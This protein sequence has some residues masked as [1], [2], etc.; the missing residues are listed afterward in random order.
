MSKKKFG[1]KNQNRPPKPP[2]PAK[3]QRQSLPELQPAPTRRSGGTLTAR[4]ITH[5]DSIL[6]VPLKFPP[7]LI[8][9][10]TD[11]STFE[12]NWQHLT[13]AFGLPDPAQF[14]ALTVPVDA[15]D[16]RSLLR[17]VQVCE[18]ISTYSVVSHK[19]GATLSMKNG[20]HEMTFE[21]VDDEEAVGFSVRFRQLH[22]STAGDPDFSKVANI[23]AKYAKQETDSDADQRMAILTEW[24]QARGQLMN[25]PLQNIVCRM[26]LEEN[27]CPPS[28]IGD[29]EMYG[30]VDPTD[31]INLFN[32]GELIHFG[33]RSAEYDTL[34]ED[35]EREGIEHHNFMLAMLGLVHLYFGFAKLIQTAIGVNATVTAN[36]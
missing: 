25:R 3:K 28:Q 5:Q 16:R 22:H 34:A 20:E 1:R 17:F 30:D 13:Y 14:P 18:T 33:R 2:R 21:Q 35:P 23:L 12:Y 26:V 9:R 8:E 32:Y 29:H 24:R 6:P 4:F 11:P 19:G 31:I 10:A 27:G 36:R 15:A 7:P